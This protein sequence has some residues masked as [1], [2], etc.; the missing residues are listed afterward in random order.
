MLD[1]LTRVGQKCPT[2]LNSSI[3]FDSVRFGLKIKSI[4]YWLYFN[5][6]GLDLNKIETC[7]NSKI[8][9][10]LRLYVLYKL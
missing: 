3:Q 4:S 2:E 8:K 7:P 9:F 10:Y 5:R 6:F 1:G